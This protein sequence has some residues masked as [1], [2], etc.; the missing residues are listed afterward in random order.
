MPPQAGSRYAFCRAVRDAQSRLVLTPPEPYRY[1]PLP[2]T[3]LHLVAEGDSLFSLAG[4]YFAPLPRACGFWWALADF[5]ADPMFDPTLALEVGRTLH[6]PSLRVLTD[7]ILGEARR[8]EF[9]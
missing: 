2:D 8:R 5:Q 6:I 4:R 9:G 3:R 7:V 1:R